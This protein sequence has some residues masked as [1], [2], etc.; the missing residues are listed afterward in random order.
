MT[1]GAKMEE[2]NSWQKG[3]GK[4]GGKGQEKSGKGET[5]MFWT[6]G[7]TGHIAGWCRKGG[8]KNLYVTQMKMTVRTLKNQLKIKRISRHGA[9]WK[10][11]KK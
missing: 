6:C 8:N 9:Y 1:K 3:S 10:R 7:K 4:K 11:A 5:K 2:K